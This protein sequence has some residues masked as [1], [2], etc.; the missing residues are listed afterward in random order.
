MS[1]L[2]KGFK[3]LTSVFDPSDLKTAAADCESL[4]TDNFIF[5]DNGTIRSLFAPHWYNDT[6]RD[7]VYNNPAIPY[8]KEV[9]GKDIYVHQVH[10]NY[11]KAHTGG[12]Y[13]WHSDYT[14]W[15]AHDG[16]LTDNAI[17]VLFLLDDMTKDNGPLVILEGSHTIPV[18]KQDA[19]SWTIKHDAAET[20]GMITEDMVSKTAYKR[21]T[22]VS[23]AGDV[24]LMHANAWHTSSANTSNKDRNI[25]FVCYNR[26]D[27]K[28]TL[29]TRP[30]HI[31]L[32][33]FTPVL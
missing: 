10:F 11:K 27:N 16:M 25:L 19:N 6:V 26:L 30:D 33:D 4:K 9:L 32:R 7:F 1:Y 5:E 14:F 22:V 12:E 8:V 20:D 21:H 24:V 28:T 29:E 18:L 13:A 23:S 2:E 15:E 17:S 31:V 3:I